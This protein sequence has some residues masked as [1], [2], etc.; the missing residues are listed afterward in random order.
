MIRLDRLILDKMKDYQ[1]VLNKSL[2]SD[3]DIEEFEYE[4]RCKTFD[5]LP[6]LDEKSEDN[7]PVK[8]LLYKM[9]FD[10]LIPEGIE[11]KP[12]KLFGIVKDE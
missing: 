7:M 5:N 11:K 8:K 9:G 6:Y 4:S 1:L 3:K 12:V 2:L 10:R